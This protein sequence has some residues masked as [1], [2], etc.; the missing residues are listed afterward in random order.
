[1]R[2]EPPEACI[3]PPRAR[4]AE[5]D[6]A[7]GVAATM[8]LEK[9]NRRSCIFLLVVLAALAALILWASLGGVSSETMGDDVTADVKAPAGT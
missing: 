1:M 4:Q 8:R 5:P 7:N 3:F 9:Q 6:G 2:L